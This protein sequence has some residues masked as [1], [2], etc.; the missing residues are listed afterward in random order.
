MNPEVFPRLIRAFA[1]NAWT[2]CWP[3]PSGTWFEKA[4]VGQ[5]A[6]FANVLKGNI[7][8][9]R[10]ALKKLLVGRVELAPIDAGN[11]KRSYRFTGEVNSGVVL[12]DMVSL[13]VITLGFLR[14]LVF[15]QAPSGRGGR[16]CGSRRVQS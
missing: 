10:Q 2:H 14:A 16:G 9:A 4:V 8:R 13:C 11:G 7:P 6:R 5:L 12:D 1:S 3:P 15:P